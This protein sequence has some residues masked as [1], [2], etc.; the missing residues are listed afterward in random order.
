M[1]RH[2]VSRCGE[3]TDRIGVRI[4][5]NDERLDSFAVIVLRRRGPREQNGRPLDP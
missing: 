3:V 2:I 1:Q 4:P 5:F